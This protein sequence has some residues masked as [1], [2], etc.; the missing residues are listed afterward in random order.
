M[1][2]TSGI[3][4]NGISHRIN[5]K[6]RTDRNTDVT[7]WYPNTKILGVKKNNV[8][9]TNVVIAGNGVLVR[10]HDDRGTPNGNTP[11]V[12]LN[13]MDEDTDDHV[14]IDR[15]WNLC[16]TQEKDYV[17]WSEDVTARVYRSG[18]SSVTNSV[19]KNGY[20]TVK[21]KNLKIESSCSLDRGWIVYNCSSDYLIF[22]ENVKVDRRTTVG[23]S[24]IKG[25]GSSMVVKG[26]IHNLN[27][28]DVRTLVR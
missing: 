12:H 10:P 7:K 17:V 9:K 28:I 14:K 26:R 23:I 3:I 1:F 25:N 4:R 19:E 11:I 8:V 6:P 5:P 13:L 16:S 22:L 24:I 18:C 21:T 20:R 27:N 15:G 2:G